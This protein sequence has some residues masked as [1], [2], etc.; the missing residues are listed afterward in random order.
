MKAS[1]AI[2]I[3]AGLFLLGL[4]ATI[5]GT[6]ILALFNIPAFIIVFGGTLGAT[7]AGTSFD[8][9]KAI[10][11]L[12]VKAFK[13]AEL[14]LVGRHRVLT[15]LA[16]R[17]RR[18]GLL[19][20]DQDVADIE[21]EFTR[22]GMQLVVDGTDPEVVREIM[23]V[24]IDGMAHRHATYADPFEKGAGFAPTM[25]I[26]GTVMGLIS[27]L[28]N[29]S[30]PASLGPSISVAFIATLYGVGMANC[31]FLPVANKLKQLSREEVELR[32]M[33]LEGILAI[34]AG[35]NPRV[36]SDKLLSFIPPSARPFD[37][38]G[39]SGGLVDESLAPD[40]E[41]AA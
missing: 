10:P 15:D 4:G 29:L 8:R 20:L 25:G 38:D 7:M 13:G 6:S 24:Q 19:A 30:D 26:I 11:K 14:D 34:Q 32:T 40:E 23:E 31:V 1:T 28:K 3:L 33:T 21:D 37:D 27:V 35:E 12:Y 22:K 17:A 36:V 41:L 2:G 18:E 5:E 16:E 39:E 9:I